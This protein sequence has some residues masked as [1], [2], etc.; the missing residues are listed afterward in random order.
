MIFLGPFVLAWG[1]FFWI[2]VYIYYFNGL[3]LPAYLTLVFLS[4]LFFITP[5]TSFYKCLWHIPREDYLFYDDCRAQLPQEYDRLNPITAEKGIADYVAFL[6]K[7]KEEDRATSMNRSQDNL[8]EQFDINKM[9]EDM[10][11]IPSI[12]GRNTEIT[13]K[14]ERPPLSRSRARR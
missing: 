4:F 14:V 5:F 6:Q 7:K 2:C 8:L 3:A 10:T 1:G 9:L 13:R 11:K 12:F